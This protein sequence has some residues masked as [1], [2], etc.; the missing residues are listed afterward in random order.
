MNARLVSGCR[1]SLQNRI[2]PCAKEEF[3]EADPIVAKSV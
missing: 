3:G 2:P 1:D